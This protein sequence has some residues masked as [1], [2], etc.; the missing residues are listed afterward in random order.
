MELI[1]VVGIIAVLSSI[2]VLN[3]TDI[4]DN[5]RTNTNDATIQTVEKSLEISQAELGESFDV[6]NNI[7]IQK[8]NEHIE[9]ISFTPGNPA[10]ASYDGSKEIQIDSSLEI[11]IVTPWLKGG[12]H[13]IAY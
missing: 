1:I 12:S 6:T 10:T 4:F 11:T 9:N 7:H 8:L 2:A 3:F 5:A 13:E